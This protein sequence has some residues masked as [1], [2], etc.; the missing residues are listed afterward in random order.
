M[1]PKIEERYSQQILLTTFKRATSYKDM[2]SYDVV[3]HETFKVACVARKLLESDKEWE[4]CLRE[5]TLM[6]SGS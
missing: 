3:Q 5:A 1:S 2:R 4:Q 6:Q